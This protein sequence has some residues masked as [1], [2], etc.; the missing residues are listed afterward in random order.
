MGEGITLGE[1]KRDKKGK[2]TA[3]LQATTKNREC[4]RKGTPDCS[5]PLAEEAQKHRP[6]WTV[7]DGKNI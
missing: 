1:K 7:L 2:I 6:S 3:R 5:P 4:L